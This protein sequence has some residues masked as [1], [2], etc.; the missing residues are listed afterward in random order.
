MT[1]II[2]GLVPFVAL[3]FFVGCRVHY[4]E[5]S[6]PSDEKEISFDDPRGVWVAIRPNQ[7]ASEPWRDEWR[8]RHDNDM[9]GYSYGAKEIPVIQDYHRRQGIRIFDAA[10]RPPDVYEPRAACNARAN[11]MALLLVHEDDVERMIE[12]GFHR[13][14]PN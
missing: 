13:A 6:R 2:P 5:P 12:F 8:E 7:C 3:L 14:G 4:A 10:T 1:K 9:H 11:Y